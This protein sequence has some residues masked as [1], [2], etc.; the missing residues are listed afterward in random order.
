MARRG[1]SFLAGI[2]TGAAL[3]A[4]AVFFWARPVQPSQAPVPPA[5]AANELPKPAFARLAFADVPGWAEDGM[6]GVMAAFRLSCAKMTA[7]PAPDFRGYGTAQDWAKA[8][9]G[10]EAATEPRA[11][12][13]ARF[14][15][16]RVTG[17]DGDT[18]LL[19]GYYE[20]VLKGSRTQSA[21][22]PE[23]VLGR[24]SDLVMADAA[25]FASILKGERLAGKVIDGR[26]VPYEDRAAIVAGALSGRA[27]TLL[28]LESRLDH[29][30]LQVQ[31]SGRI[32]LA[33]GGTTRL[34]Y[35]GQNGWPYTAI[36]RVLI[37]WGE[38]TRETMSMQTIAAWVGKNPDRAD[39]LMNK[40]RSFV[41]FRETPA[42]NDT[43]GP[44]GGQ[45]VPLVPGR[46]LA[47]DSRLYPYGIPVFIE[48]EL[49][50]PAGKPVPARRLMIAQDTG[51]AI[52]GVVR[53]DY[54]FGWGEAAQESAG[55]QKQKLKL[56]FLLPKGVTPPQSGIAP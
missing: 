40:N 38:G 42:L 20:P 43:D 55:R 10:V 24:P 6:D 48:T 17:P 37:E 28:F 11:F 41:F 2:L 25:G 34:N 7:S 32:E 5:A 45:G 53:A 9:A 31:G 39:E 47:I 23:P 4:A 52:R 13:E 50:D 1:V 19:T 18:G 29:F 46:A 54:F 14:E 22:F 8:C 12:F 27:A 33:E 3:A 36:G 15:A 35:D 49:M 56:V 21:A 51:G 44:L 26:L 30:F 16:W